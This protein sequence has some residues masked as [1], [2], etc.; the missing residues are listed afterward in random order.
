MGHKFLV[1]I[2]EVSVSFL[3]VVEVSYSAVANSDIY[4]TFSS[5]FGSLFVQ[6][7]YTPIHYF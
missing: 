6:Y 4:I 3:P 1:Y 7:R 2:F 5:L